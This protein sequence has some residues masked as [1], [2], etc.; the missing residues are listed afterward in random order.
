MMEIPFRP[1]INQVSQNIMKKKRSIDHLYPLSASKH[2]S[3]SKYLTL[4]QENEQKAT[5]KSISFVNQS[6]LCSHLYEE[7]QKRKEKV[8][9]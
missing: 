1:Q 4:Q 9:K 2:K 6:N 5:R 7:A 3:K 8:Q